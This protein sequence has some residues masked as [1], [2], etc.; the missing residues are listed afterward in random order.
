MEEIEIC[1]DLLVI[2]GG[3]TGIKAASEIAGLGYKVLL[4]EKGSEIGNSKELI[5]PLLCLGRRKDKNFKDLL[6]KVTSNDNI[7]VCTQTDLIRT[8]GVSGDFSVMTLR[9][10]DVVEHK[11]GAIVIATEFSVESLHEKYGL[12]LSE[13]VLTQSR[14]E[15]ILASEKERKETLIIDP[16]EVVFLAGF[17]QEGNPL[18]MERVMRSVLAI[19]KIKGCNAYVCAGD[20]KVA[21]D[22]LE[23]MYKES[24]EKGVVYFKP[25]KIPKITQDGEVLGIAFRDP[26]M[27]SDVELAPDLL[28][29]EEELSAN[30]INRKVAE[31]LR[32]DLDPWGF[33]QNDNVHLFPVRSNR[34]GIFVIGSSREVNNLP[35]AW[36]DAE[37]ASLE[38]KDFLNNEKKAVP[39]DM[40]VVDRAKCTICL[41]C[42]RCCP[43]G[44]IYWDSRAIISPVACQGCGIC[45]SECPNNAIQIG[46]FKDVQ[47]V[48]E[49]KKCAESGNGDLRVIAFCCENSGFEAWQMAKAFK[50]KLPSGLCVIKVPCAGKIDIHYIMTAFVEGADGVLVLA[51]HKGNCKS[52]K[53]NIYAGLRTGKAQEVLEETGFEKERLEFIT[54]ASN[55]GREFSSIVVNME[56]KIKKLGSSPLGNSS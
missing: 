38:V 33:L 39:K 8:T 56:E 5:R 17:C 9:G 52:E 43:H 13:N 46:G 14:I 1:T 22:S 27:R 7:K 49:I 15:A 51:C 10:T 55:M 36:V 50:M 45:A 19:S 42:Y 29:V 53:G 48:E 2:G 16:K 34:E 18:V 31:L 6:D 12:S 54:I 47:I 11:V 44:A 24:R 26:I 25:K 3:I 23:R 30:Q 20:I 35:W 4:I 32:I 37:N 40:A 28:V 21:S 41:M